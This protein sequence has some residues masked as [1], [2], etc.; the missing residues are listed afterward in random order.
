VGS[1]SSTGSAST[2]GKDDPKR[3]SSTG[4]LRG[5]GNLFG[6]VCDDLIIFR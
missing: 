1:L 6:C 3:K 4:T 5:W 2:K